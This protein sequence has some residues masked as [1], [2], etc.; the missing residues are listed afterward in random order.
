MPSAATSDP[1]IQHAADGDAA[2]TKDSCLPAGVTL[3]VDDDERSLDENLRP[4]DNQIWLLD[5]DGE[6]SGAFQTTVYALIN[7]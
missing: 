7:V 2:E 4:M 3:P 5:V 1:Q 6:V